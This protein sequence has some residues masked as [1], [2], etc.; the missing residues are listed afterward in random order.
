[1]TLPHEQ[2]L[3]RRF[4]LIP[5]LELDIEMATP[6]GGRLADALATLDVDEGVP[7]PGSPAGGCRASSLDGRGGIHS[8]G[9]APGG[10][11][12]RSGGK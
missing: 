9:S 5:A 2:L 3:Q 1:M 12:P 4:V 8:A 7:G 10:T 6:A 11:S